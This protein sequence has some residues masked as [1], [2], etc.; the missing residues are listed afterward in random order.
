MAGM[1]ALH[2]TRIVATPIRGFPHS[3][4]RSRLEL[5]K[6]RRVLDEEAAAAR[7]QEGEAQILLHV[8]RLLI[9]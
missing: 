2:L 6:T 7:A 5:D 1:L 4:P 3:E 9:C 8:V